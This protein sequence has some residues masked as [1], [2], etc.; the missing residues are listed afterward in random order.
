MKS[1]AIAGK[2]YWAAV[3]VFSVLY[4][5]GM[6]FLSIEAVLV[7]LFISALV[8][9]FAA[10]IRGYSGP[11]RGSSILQFVFS[12]C[13]L[14]FL[15]GLLYTLRIFSL[16][17]MTI[18][19]VVIFSVSHFLAK[20]DD[21]DF[22]SLADSFAVALIYLIVQQPPGYLMEPGDEQKVI[23]FYILSFAFMS[24]SAAYKFHSSIGTKL[25]ILPV[26]ILPV[27]W[28]AVLY[29]YPSLAGPVAVLYLS[30][31]QLFKK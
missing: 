28:L 25:A 5:F 7:S 30:L 3:C 8:S 16:D 31:P 10:L 17:L 6:R 22:A 2:L 19:T 23:F 11:D 20:R 18:A 9:P 4:A 12:I 29:H 26:I 13:A 14:G 21:A 1:G 27:I 24:G 15:L